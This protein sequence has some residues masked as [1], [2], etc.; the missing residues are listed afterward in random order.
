[1][2]TNYFD[3][4]LNLD[5]QII[6]PQVAEPSNSLPQRMIQEKNNTL[7]FNSDRN[8][9]LNKD[10]PL[11]PLVSKDRTIQLHRVSKLK[12]KYLILAE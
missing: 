3:K 12:L 5:S 2:P 7:F 11:N 9:V 6:L 8:I 1:M 10:I 4:H